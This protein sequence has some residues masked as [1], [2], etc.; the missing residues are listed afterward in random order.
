MAKSQ[1]L[2]LHLLQVHNELAWTGRLFLPRME[3]V[4]ASWRYFIGYIGKGETGASNLF[5][6]QVANTRLLGGL[7]LGSRPGNVS[8]RKVAK[9]ALSHKT[10][11]LETYVK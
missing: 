7:H 3:T 2:I 6:S 1:L 4:H 10:L 9:P 11:L 5:G 8:W